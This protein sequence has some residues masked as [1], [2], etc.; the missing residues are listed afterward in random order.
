MEKII[1]SQKRFIPMAEY[2]RIS[3]LS[4]PTVKKALETGQLKGIKT[5]CGHWRIDT[6]ADSPEYSAIIERLDRQERLIKAL[7]SHF[8]VKV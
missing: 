2:Q 5:E 6:Q 4:Y 7:S 8:G 1:D 3:G